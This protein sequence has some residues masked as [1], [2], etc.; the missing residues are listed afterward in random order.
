MRLPRGLHIPPEEATSNWPA[1][2]LE[3]GAMGGMAS[4]ALCPGKGEPLLTPRGDPQKVLCVHAWV[5]GLARLWLDL[6]R[7]P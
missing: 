4:T 7:H 5:S 2:S 6:Y 3:V 1:V